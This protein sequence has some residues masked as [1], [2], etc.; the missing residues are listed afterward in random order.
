MPPYPLKARSVSKCLI[1]KEG[2]LDFSLPQGFLW[3]GPGLKNHIHRGSYIR[4]YVTYIRPDGPVQ[5]NIDTKL[6]RLF[7]RGLCRVGVGVALHGT[8]RRGFQEGEMMGGFGLPLGV[9][10]GTE[11]RMKAGFSTPGSVQESGCFFRRAVIIYILIAYYC[12]ILY[13]YYY[14]YYYVCMY[15]LLLLLYII[16][17]AVLS[18]QK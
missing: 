10:A 2:G 12:Y 14:Y 3:P 16:M 1:R 6:S 13:M 11:R 5:A 9:S 4:P 8:T 15:V 18:D 17:I 7:P